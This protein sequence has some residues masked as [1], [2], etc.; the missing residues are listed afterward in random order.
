M[1]TLR[2]ARQVVQTLISQKAKKKG[3]EGSLDL[4]GHMDEGV[5]DYLVK[6]LMAWLCSP[7]HAHCA[8]KNIVTVL[9]RF[10]NTVTLF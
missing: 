4:D 6:L 10:M 2:Q 9:S 7:L 8:R 1:R 5:V 3:K